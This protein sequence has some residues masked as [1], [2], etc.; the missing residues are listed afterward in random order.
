[1]TGITD[2]FFVGFAGFLYVIGEYKLAF[3][4]SAFGIANNAG[5][6]VRAV[7]DPDWY[8]RKRLEANLPVDFFNSGIRSLLAIKVIVIGVLFWAAWRAGTHA[9]YF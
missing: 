7:V 9:G 2:Y 4:F 6:A 5:A 8:M 1:M 3:W